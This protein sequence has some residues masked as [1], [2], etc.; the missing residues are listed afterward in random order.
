[1]DHLRHNWPI[2]NGIKGLNYQDVSI[3]DNNY[4]N[5]PDNNVEY[6]CNPEDLVLYDYRSNGI[7][8]GGSLLTTVPRDLPVLV[9]GAGS[10]RLGDVMYELGMKPI[11]QCDFSET[12]V[13]RREKRVNL[14]LTPMMFWK[15]IDC[16]LPM[17]DLTT[18]LHPDKK[19]SVMKFGSVWDKGMIDALYLAGGEAFEDIT[20]IIASASG[21]LSPDGVFVLLS[22]SHPQYMLPLL[23]SPHF[24]K[25]EARL[26]E[27]PADIYLYRLCK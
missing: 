1:M 15:C 21:V 17:S 6:G 27:K 9:I 22:R 13:Q 26:L 23:K 14:T 4:K 2:F 24:S 3:W 12:V 7:N 18:Y 8:M 20:K 11:V 16:R 19:I 10:S 25:I 5:S